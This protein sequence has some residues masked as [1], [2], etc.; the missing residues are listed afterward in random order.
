M[1]T[2]QLRPPRAWLWLLG[3]VWAGAA[4]AASSQVTADN[5][6]ELVESSKQEGRLLV[7]SNVAEYNWRP[8]LQGFA[9]RYPWIRVDTLDMGPAEVFERYYAEVSAGRRTADL[10]VSG[11]PGPWLRFR[12]RGGIEPYSSLE[13]EHLPEWSRP[14]PGLYTIS[15]DP[16]IIIYNKMLLAEKDWPDSLAA[17]QTMAT[18]DAA[19]FRNKLSTYN[20]AS[21]VFGYAIHWTVAKRLGPTAWPVFETLGSVTRPEDGGAIMVEKVT[22]GEY[23]AAFFVS[24][25]TVFPRMTQAGR[26]KVI[27]WSFINDGT[28]VFVRGMAVTRAASNQSSAKLLLDFILSRDGQIAV[29]EGGMTP[30]RSDV[31]PEDVPYVALSTIEAEIGEQNIVLIGYDPEMVQD[32]DGFNARWKAAYR[33][34]D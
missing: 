27:G 25:I 15:A 5:H 7:Y 4:A 11:A 22:T 19:R 3:L 8:I 10:I 20:A 30:Y 12:D 21:H 32:M 28:P 9:A 1:K 29:G 24:G 17:L 23:L 6:A 18:E 14:L 13:D 16:M 26:D 31:K 2:R 34:R 33:L